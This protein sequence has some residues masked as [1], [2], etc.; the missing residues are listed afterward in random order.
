MER[1][2]SLFRCLNCVLEVFNS[3]FVFKFRF[4]EKGISSAIKAKKERESKQVYVGFIRIYVPTDNPIT[5]CDTY[6]H[7]RARRT[8]IFVLKYLLLEQCERTLFGLYT[9]LS[10]YRLSL[11]YLLK[12]EGKS[13]LLKYQD[14]I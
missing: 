9:V 3:V 12:L 1:L 5:P 14:G 7:T 13:K 2:I 4:L 6:T 11:K 10:K 8:H